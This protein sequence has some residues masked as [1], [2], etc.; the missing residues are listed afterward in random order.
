MGSI[1]NEYCA[2]SM[3]QVMNDIIQTIFIM[4]YEQPRTLVMNTIEHLSGPKFTR[5]LPRKFQL[6][7]QYR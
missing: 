6:F 5:Y 2:Y 3:M 7:Y 1:L 4:V